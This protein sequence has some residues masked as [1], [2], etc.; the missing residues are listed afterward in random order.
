MRSCSLYRPYFKVVIFKFVFRNLNWAFSN[1]RLLRLL[2]FL[3]K[4]AML[5]VKYA[6]NSPLFFCKMAEIELLPSRAA[7]L[8]S[9]V[10]SA[11]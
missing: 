5:V 9:I 6:A 11:A 2:H 8:V 1:L 4:D 10:L 3:R 7:I